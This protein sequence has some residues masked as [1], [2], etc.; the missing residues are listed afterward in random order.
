MKY[1]I[2]INGWTEILR[3][4]LAST[5]I[6]RFSIYSDQD[7]MASHITLTCFPVS[8]MAVR[9]GYQFFTQN[10]QIACALVPYFVSG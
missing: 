4:I 6:I 7:V 9:Y 1:P 10:D 3:L 5:S 2:S 8:F